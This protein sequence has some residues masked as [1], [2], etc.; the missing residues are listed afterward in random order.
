M[1]LTVAVLIV[2]LALAS[3]NVRRAVPFE[4]L[5]ALGLSSVFLLV[6]FKLDR[7]G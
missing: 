4:S 6:L 3:E 2:A 7:L 5:V 1:A